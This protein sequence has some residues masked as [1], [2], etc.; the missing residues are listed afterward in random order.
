MVGAFLY[1][2]RAS[3]KGFG[4]C[5][6]LFKRGLDGGCFPLFMDLDGGCFLLFL[7]LSGRV[8]L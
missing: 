8:Y 4:W 3:F 5:V 6:L 2:K 1:L 7:G